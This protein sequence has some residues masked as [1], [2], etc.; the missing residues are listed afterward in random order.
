MEQNFRDWDLKEKAKR[1]EY[2]RR[3]RAAW[4]DYEYGNHGPYGEPNFDTFKTMMERT[5][6]LRVNM[7]AGNIEGSYQIV[8][9]K[10]HLLF[11]LK[12]GS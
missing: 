9:E 1:N 3:L 5:Y 2:W 8:D 12:Y 6:G 10:K 7:V 11:L 4:H